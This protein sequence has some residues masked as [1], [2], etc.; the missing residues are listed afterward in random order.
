MGKFKFKNYPP[1]KLSAF[2]EAMMA[3]KKQSSEPSPSAK[4]KIWG[5]SVAD[6]IK[7]AKVVAGLVEVVPT[8]KVGIEALPQVQNSQSRTDLEKCRLRKEIEDLRGEKLGLEEK[9]NISRRK[10]EEKDE[11]LVRMGKE[12]EDLWREKLDANQTIKELK[13]KEIEATQTIDKLRVRLETALATMLRVN[14]EDLSKLIN[15]PDIFS[16]AATNAEEEENV[17]LPNS[18]KGESYCLGN[19]IVNADAEDGVVMPPEVHATSDNSGGSGGV[20]S[21]K[22]GGKDLA[23]S[24]TKEDGASTSRFV[25]GSAV[26]ESNGIVQDNEGKAADVKGGRSDDEVGRGKAEVSSSAGIGNVILI[27]D[28]DDETDTSCG[29]TNKR[30]RSDDSP[31]NR[32]IKRKT[33]ASTTPSLLPSRLEET[34]TDSDNDSCSSTHMENLIASM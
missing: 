3:A 15:G 24:G 25:I 17:N 29:Q 6:Q 2:V 1:D 32:S 31:T 18:E 13:R 20:G 16:A 26:A 22:E 30:N 19:D 27:S 11:R 34:C 23:H 5:S 33:S 28:T 10:C 8:E 4:R 21:S 12:I 9:L 7:K 14:V